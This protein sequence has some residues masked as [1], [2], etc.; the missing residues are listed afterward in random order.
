VK[1]VLLT[2]DIEDWHPL[3]DEWVYG[4]RTAPSGRVPKQVDEIRRVLDSLGARGTFFCLGSTARDYPAVIRSLAADGH[5][6]AS[7][8][9]SHKPVYGL[10]PS[11]FEADLKRAHE[12][13]SDL[14]GRPPVGFRAPQFSINPATWWAFDILVKYGY[15]YDSSIFPVRH[16]RYGVPGFDRYPKS[17][18]AGGSTIVELPLATARICGLNL[19]IAGGGYFR[20][21]PKWALRRVVN[22]IA[23]RLSPFTTYFHPYE[24][25]PSPLRLTVQASSIG[26]AIKAR[27]F[28]ALQ[29]FGRF[30]VAG[31]ILAIAGDARLEPCCEFIERLQIRPAVLPDGVPCVDES[32]YRHHDTARRVE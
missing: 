9:Y 14:N 25:D 12:V 20:F 24:F 13:L 11:E 15:Q 19:P 31:K 1:S 18:P 7:H 16:R 23:Q 5:E 4:F 30:S 26:L 27:R 6:I 17:I 10:S 2:F 21:T 32:G 8:G 22:S 3:A 29:N 28:T